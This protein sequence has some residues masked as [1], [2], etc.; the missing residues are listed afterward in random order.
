MNGLSTPALVLRHL[1]SGV[2]GS[3]LVGALVGLAVL[4]TA[5]APRALAAVGTEELRVQLSSASP[6]LIDLSAS[7][8][9]GFAQTTAE[10][11]LDR[12]LGAMDSAIVHTPE[13]LTDPLA[14]A[15]LTPQWVA[16]T[17]ADDASPPGERRLRLI[18]DLALDLRFSDRIR[19][20]EG[21]L[22]EPWR[23]DLDP[24]APIDVALSAAVADAAGLGIG[25]VLGYLPADLRVAAVYE[26]VD[27]DD[28]YWQHQASLLAPIV[29][30][31][32]G[33]LPT[34]RTSVYVAP[35]TA[36]PLQDPL[37][38]GQL[39]A[40]VPI[41]PARIAL[42][43]AE[44]VAAQVRELASTATF[45]P[46]GGS[47][48]F[49]SGLPDALDRVQERV[50]AVSALLA[51]SL[52]GLLGVLLAVVALGIRSVIARRTPALSLLAA[53]GASGLQLRSMMALEGLLVAVPPAAI[54]MALAAVLLPGDPGLAG[55][56]AP[57]L[58]ALAP[59]VLFAALTSP[60]GL[61]PP[62]N[63][64]RM[65][66]TSRARVV[67]ELG[68]VGL[69]AV[70]LW[71]LSRRGLVPSAAAVGVDP[72][73]SATPLLLA[74]A[75][76]VIALRLYPAPLL[77][78]QRLLRARDGAVGLLGSARAVRDP[79]LGFATALALIVGVAIVV[80]SAVFVTTVRH[81]L[82]VGARDAVGA[83]LQVRAF[84]LDSGAVDAARAVPG[85]RDATTLTRA[86][87]VPFVDGA[88]ESD[89][90]LV[91]ADT[92]AL[93]RIRSDLPELTPTAGD[94]VP[95]LVSSDW[96]DR[97]GSD[98]PELGDTVVRVAGTIP[99]TALPGMTRHWVLVDA[100]SADELGLGLPAPERLLVSLDPAADPATVAAD[101]DDAVAEA[102]PQSVRGLVVVLDTA[103]SL[104][105]ARSPVIQ[106]V[107]GALLLAAAASLLLI[108]LTV[109]LASV[110][111]A[112]ARNR[113]LGVLRILGMSTPQLRGVLA[114][115]LGPLA[116]TALVVGAGLGVA[117]AGI[118]T[119]VLDLRPFVG[120]LSQPGPVIDPLAV[121]AAL[122]VFLLTVVAA[123]A[124]AV[125]LGRRLAPA[126]ALK[127][128]DA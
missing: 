82:E 107:E 104:R 24:E 79:A 70:A 120:G 49:R 33:V 102:Q 84:V 78:L 112:A 105:E 7:G 32:P 34:I 72:L 85:V 13:R 81:G 66:G 94:P 113:L 28:T 44:V 61:R 126:G 46:R 117:L 2:A 128:G 74:L 17:V 127:V 89:V 67:V 29:E 51:L 12:L 97:I 80:F 60:R 91:V 86:I 55:W 111:A 54:G 65:R 59:I 1:R 14:S 123:G 110:A 116:L 9:V 40:W 57:V 10:G 25:D 26:P 42:V 103:S 114:W 73:L 56:V 8:R 35:E 64:L 109:V 95:V 41:D 38:N 15:T 92:E 50:T 69:A 76:C 11:D 48:E 18:V 88:S 96:A 63:D 118:V 108:V 124:I 75:V 58:L 37:Q 23:P 119:S 3:V 98:D 68:I 71:L 115:E 77:A 53:R 101:L 27:A 30:A 45:L 125:A 22:P 99:P 4:A 106:G 90:F 39:E 62:R 20:L 5:L 31:E 100:T 6:V 47:L 87:G 16:R 93:H 122:L 19:V 83:D 121:A 21:E 36:I 43:D 52:S